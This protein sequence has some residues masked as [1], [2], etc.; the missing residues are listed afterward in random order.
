MTISTDSL[1][2]VNGPEDGA[3]FPIVR[4]P[5]DVGRDPCCTACIT[6]DIAVQSRHARVWAVSEGYRV[7]R[8]TGSAVLV[9]GRR[10][11]R[12]RS[13]ILRPGGTVKVGHTLLALQCAQDGLAS[14]SR[15][16]VTQSD[17]V[18]FLRWA[19]RRGFGSL[20]RLPGVA[21]RLLRW[22]AGHKILVVLALVAL[23]VL[24]PPFRG[25]VDA[26]VVGL[27]N[28]MLRFFASLALHV[29]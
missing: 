20:H 29:F 7:R 19:L 8:V 5:F 22:A 27:I 18:C 14:R 28:R 25:A 26:R 23:Y 2:V 11:G 3:E 16:L 17:L 21:M 15:G 12:F 1:V 24:Y 9:D 10:V 4:A 13:R 6:L